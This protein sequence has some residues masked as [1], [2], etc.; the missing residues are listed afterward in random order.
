MIRVAVSSLHTSP[1]S[2]PGHGDAEAMNIY[3]RELASS[4]AQTGVGYNAHILQI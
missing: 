2:L 1:L 3:V 4:L